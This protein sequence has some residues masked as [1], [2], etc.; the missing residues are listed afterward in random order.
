M[1]AVKW[2]GEYVPSVCGRCV[3]HLQCREGLPF[4]ST[5]TLQ[6]VL[7]SKEMWLGNVHELLL[8]RV[9]LTTTQSTVRVF[10]VE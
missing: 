9:G 6:C 3:D 2:Y 1:V 7:C 4:I 5:F 8:W 10:I